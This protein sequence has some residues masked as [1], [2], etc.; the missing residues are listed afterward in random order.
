MR[1]LV[2][3]LGFGLLGWGQ[4]FERIIPYLGLT[5][6]QLD[7]ILQRGV[8][9][10]TWE[11]GRLERI[12][13]LQTEIAAEKARS[14]LDPMALGVRYVEI[15][16]IRREI[17][18]RRAALVPRNVALLTEEPRGKLA[19]LEAAMRLR[20]TWA[21]VNVLGLV[22]EECPAMLYCY[23]L[24]YRNPR[25]IELDSVPVQAAKA[26]L[27][28][29]DSQIQMLR[30]QHR[31]FWTWAGQRDELAE[32]VE[33]QI[34]METARSPLDPMALGVRYVAVEMIRR[35]I[36]E[37]ETAWMAANLRLLTEGQRRR[38]AELERQMNLADV[39]DE[40]RALQVLAPDCTGR[41]FVTPFSGQGGG[42]D[43]WCDASTFVP[44]P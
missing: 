41:Y 29:T 14:P 21:E 1:G 18:A 7:Q 26:Y 22:A 4:Q 11:M 39:G 34:A 16:T 10:S 27:G 5:D 28:L 37:E 44:V 36:Q 31:M 33:K 13:D 30:F 8:D 17:V 15:E 2:L 35:E 25:P 6:G 3:F 9:F 12:S 19:P 38:L 24:P 42:L 23:K 32:E 40:A 20:G 43:T